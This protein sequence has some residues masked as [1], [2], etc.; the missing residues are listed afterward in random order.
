MK[1]TEITKWLT[2]AAALYLL[3][4]LPRSAVGLE[5][6]LT[7]VC[8]AGGA[9]SVDVAQGASSRTLT[10]P[11]EFVCDDGVEVMLTA[12]AGV[13]WRFGGW[14]GTLVSGENPFSFTLTRD[15]KVEACFVR[16]ART[17]TIT[18]DEGGTVID[19]GIGSFSFQPGTTV[20]LAAEATP[21]YRFAGWT[22]SVVE[23]KDILDASR[24]R[25]SVLISDDGTL[26]AEF[27]AITHFHEG[28]ETALEG[29][30]M[31]AR[32][33]YVDADEGVWSLDD[34]VAD[35]VSCGLTPHTAEIV[36]LTDGQALLLTSVDSR[37]ACS[38]IISVSL[39]EAGLVNPNFALTIDANTVL[40]F[41]EVGRLDQPELR[42]PLQD[43]AVP[44]CFD[45]VSLLLSD[46]KGNVLAY[47]LQRCPDAV[48][49]ASNARLRDTYREIFLDPSGVFYQRNLLSDFRTIPAFDRAVAQIRSVEFRVDQHGSALI[50][51]LTIAPGTLDGNVPVYRFW[52]P[53]RQR[54]FFTAVAAERQSLIDLYGSTWTFEGIAYSTPS[55]DSPGAAPVY[56]FRSPAPEAYFYTISEVERDVLLRAF[57]DVWTL[58]GAAFYAYPEGRQPTDALPVFRLWSDVL[59]CHF[60]TISEME[61][62]YLIS[63]FAYLWALEGVAW[64]AYPP[65]WDSGRAM[66]LVD[67]NG[68]VHAHP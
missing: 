28:W 43:C 33:S 37:S 48:A 52:S 19:P 67:K 11:G 18:C 22:G 27:T 1:T 4:G 3:A 24:I 38:D 55:P 54:H 49:L 40:S 6:T 21:G 7:V 59:G 47:I 26:N 57:R 2:V 23:R 20:L 63:H 53:L 13:G 15:E 9:V 46:T 12:S 56:R 30:Y 61:R 29:I 17:L 41:Y 32:C 10:G 25:T 42:D 66:T 39:T 44:P 16:N 31:P 68:T 5:R 14:A 35:S 50:D 51:E 34:A 8:N 64:Y 65:R 45:N 62:D 36:K 60:Y 58:E